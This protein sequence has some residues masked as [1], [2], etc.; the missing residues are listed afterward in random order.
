LLKVLDDHVVEVVGMS[1][2]SPSAAHPELG[3]PDMQAALMKTAKGAVL[4]LAVSFAQPHPEDDNHWW[5][6]IGTRGSVEFRRSSQDKARLWLAEGQMHSKAQVDWTFRRTDEPAEARGTGHDNLDYYVHAAFRDAILD[7]KPLDFDVY[8]AMDVAACGILAAESIAQG[9]RK[10]HVPDL[11]P[12][13][14]R[15]LGQPLPPSIT[16]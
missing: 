4:R 3:W 10:L 9:S 16:P 15:R 7:G 11:R 12:G 6:V 8:K 5:Q 14:H 1:T 13:P 2:P